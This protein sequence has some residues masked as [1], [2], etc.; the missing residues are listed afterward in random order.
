MSNELLESKIRNFLK[1]EGISMMGIA[2]VGLLPNGRETQSPQSLLAEAK[3][4]ICY[5]VPIPKGIIYAERDALS[6]YWRYFNITAKSSDN[7][8]HKLCWIL[9]ENGFRSLPAYGCFPMKILNRDFW[10]VLPLIY[11]AEVAGL[12]RLSKCGLL[13][14]PKLGMR[15]LLGGVVTTADLSPTAMIKDEVCPPDCI[16]CQTVCPAKA[17]AETG[18]VNHSLCLRHAN[19]NPIAEHLLKDSSVK[20]KYS[21]E[22]INNLVGIDDHSSYTCFECLKA[23][24]L[25]DVQ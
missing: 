1:S 22:T 24:P 21:L 10:G 5:G 4:V 15:I 9:E 6:L 13:V 23:C 17:I 20:E 11:W 16:D 18:K 12:G 8:T 14:N 2:E 3:S 7:V 19:A 25:N